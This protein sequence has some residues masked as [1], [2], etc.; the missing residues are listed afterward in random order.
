MARFC[1]S[2]GFILDLGGWGFPVPF[3]FVRRSE[4]GVVESLALRLNPKTRSIRKQVKP[5]ATQ[6]HHLCHTRVSY[7]NGGKFR[8]GNL[9]ENGNKNRWNLLCGELLLSKIC[10]RSFGKNSLLHLSKTRILYLYHT[11]K[12]RHL[13]KTNI[14]Y[15]G[16]KPP[17]K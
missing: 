12:K 3:Y 14:A 13:K 16:Y 6:A 2:R 4:K 15:A 10:T 1:P 11:Q 9:L 5:Q 8:S 7:N 17:R